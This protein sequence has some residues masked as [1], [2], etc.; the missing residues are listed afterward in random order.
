[1]T[2]L[3]ALIEYNKRDIEMCNRVHE[4]EVA[5]YR[6]EY[7]PLYGSAWYNMMLHDMSIPHY[8]E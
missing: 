5:M 6:L 1:M 3:E 7:L 4:R 8:K 2:A